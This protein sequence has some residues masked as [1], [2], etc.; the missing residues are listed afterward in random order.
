[1][2]LAVMFMTPA[3]LQGRAPGRQR[4]QHQ[5]HQ[6]KSSDAAKHDKHAAA[7][8]ARA[9]RAM[10]FSQQKTTHHFRLLSDGGAIEVEAKDK[11]DG[12][13]REQIRKHLARVAKMFAEGDFATPEEVHAEV[14]PGVETLRRLRG[15][16]RYE[17][18][19]T[20]RGGRIRISTR[21]AEALATVHAYLRFQ[22][23]DHATGDSLEVEP[24]A[25]PR[26]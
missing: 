22:I 23:E 9:D 14:P 26:R 17:Y 24:Q 21:N 6:P 16:I 20:E 3:S 12:A 2:S 11:E 4:H 15:E 18:A 7:D 25:R 19:E 8:D 1:M 5:G 13:S 10:G